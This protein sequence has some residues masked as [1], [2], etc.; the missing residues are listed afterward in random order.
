MKLACGWNA[1]IQTQVF[2][3]PKRLQEREHV[4]LIEINVTHPGHRQQDRGRFVQIVFPVQPADDVS[5][6][7]RLV[8]GIKDKITI[9]LS[10][11]NETG[12]TKDNHLVPPD[13]VRLGEINEQMKSA[14][15]Q[16][17]IFYSENN[18][19][20]NCGQ[21]ITEFIQC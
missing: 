12:A 13:C 2:I 19:N 14:G 6:F 11:L 9:R 16:S 7:I 4:L 20:M 10:R 3:L 1:N 17:Y 15:L 8:D 18:D 5:R 21:L